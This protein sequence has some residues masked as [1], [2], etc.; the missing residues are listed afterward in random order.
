[1]FGRKN[2]TD[3]NRAEQYPPTSPSNAEPMESD[4]GDRVRHWD[5]PIG[6]A[7]RESNDLAISLVSLAILAIAGYLGWRLI[8]SA[9]ER[10]AETSKAG[11]GG[12]K[13]TVDPKVV[14]ALPGSEL[15]RDAAEASKA[16]SPAGQVIGKLIAPPDDDKWVL[17]EFPT[18]GERIELDAS[19]VYA[20]AKNFT[21][22]CIGRPD[23]AVTLKA[24]TRARDTP[25]AV[26][27]YLNSG[28]ICATIFDEPLFEFAVANGFRAVQFGL[29]QGSPFVAMKQIKAPTVPL[30]DV[31]KAQ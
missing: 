31:S 6:P 27:S 25:I 5:L 22:A 28:E 23:A 20:R 3:Q 12:T 14:S 1:M 29:Q 15:R 16:L 19:G 24:A 30:N 7:R 2:K 11:A 8:E 4:A 26:R 18:G 10:P 13:A 9:P 17:S 21:E